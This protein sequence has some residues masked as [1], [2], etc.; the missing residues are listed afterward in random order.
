MGDRIAVMRAGVL[1]S[2]APPASATTRPTNLFVAEFVGSPPMNLFAGHRRVDGGT[3]VRVGETRARARRLASPSRELRRPGGIAV[4]IRPEDVREASGWDGARCAAASSSSRHSAQNSWSTSRSPQPRSSGRISST[5]R[6]QPPGPSLGVEGLEQVGDAPWP[7]RPASPPHA[8]RSGRGGD[9]PAVC[10]I[11]STSRRERDPG[12]RCSRPS[13]ESRASRAARRRGSACR[14]R[15]CSRGRRGRGRADRGVGL[16]SATGRG[17]A[18]P[19]FVDLQVNGFAG[20]D[21]FSADAEGYASRARRCSRAGVTAYQPT[22][23]TSPEEELAAA[24]REVP[25]N[26]AAPRIL[27]AHLEGPFISPAAA[28]HAS[29]R[30]P[31]RSRRRLCSSGCSPPGR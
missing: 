8:G 11:S 17:I 29:R 18:A 15:P 30:V 21:F 3:P 27:G 22:F 20:V 9:R 13:P 1:S 31:A 14:R 16:N 5:P 28:R 19:G 25:R 12:G 6:A 23:I 2:S 24:L 10:S 4:G 26:G 7:L